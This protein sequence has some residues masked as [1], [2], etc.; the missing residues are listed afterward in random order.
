MMHQY[1]KGI[2]NF[3]TAKK[4]CVILA[5]H[6]QKV[7]DMLSRFSVKDFKNFENEVVLDFTNPKGYNFNDEYIKSGI[8]SKALIY[9]KNGSGK[10]NLGFAIFD[11]IKHIT[12][13]NINSSNYVHYINSNSDSEIAEF[14]YEFTFNCGKIKYNYGKKN[15]EELVF[16]EIFINDNLFARVDRRANSIAEI[17][18]EGAESLA[19][20]IG[21]SNISLVTYISKNTVLVKNDTNKCFMKFIEFVNKMLFFRSLDGNSYIGLQ[22]GS[23]GILED[24]VEKDNVKDFENFL[25][26]AGVKC[27]LVEMDTEE[28]KAIGFRFKHKTIPFYSIASQ[29]TKALALFYFW[30][31]RFKETDSVKFIFVDEYDAFYHHE[32]SELIVERLLEVGAQVIIT[33]HNTSV[34]SNDLLRP[35]CYYILTE[36][37]IKSL[38]NLT[39]KE[40]REAHN[41][42]KMF[43]AGAF[44]V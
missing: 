20:D 31:Q 39:R 14:N 25:N 23:S 32:L 2:R 38:P 6:K 9:G 42:E 34:I 35:D 15:I 4:S 22:Q 16:E 37:G 5:P 43:K 40:L 17:N 24:I 1:H 7:S 28:G 36:A 29:G 12:D 21:D 11:I 33:T 8:I 19:R 26:A 13:K 30:L 44:N 10:S 3:F 41:I 18:A 27:T